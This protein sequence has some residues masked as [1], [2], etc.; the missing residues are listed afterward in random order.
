MKLEVVRDTLSPMLCL[1]DPFRHNTILKQ[2]DKRDDWTGA[3]F[4]YRDPSHFPDGM[5]HHTRYV[6]FQLAE[7]TVPRKV[8]AA[9][10]GRIRQW[11]TEARAGLTAILT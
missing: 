4:H 8:F 3:H 2:R 11:A 10:P 7:V 9:I 1:W 5:V 6:A